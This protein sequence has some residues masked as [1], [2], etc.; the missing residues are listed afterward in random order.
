MLLHAFATAAEQLAVRWLLP[1]VPTGVGEGGVG[2]GG[3]SAGN[4]GGSDGGDGGR[5]GGGRGG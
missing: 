4:G 3:G 2:E 1:A 5:E